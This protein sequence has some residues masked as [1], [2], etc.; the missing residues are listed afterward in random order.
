MRTEECMDQDY[1][2]HV[3]TGELPEYFGNGS[4]NN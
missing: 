4:Q 2:Y 3:N 1:N